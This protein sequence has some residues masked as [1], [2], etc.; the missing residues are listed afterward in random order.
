MAAKRGKLVQVGTYLSP[1]MAV[2]LKRLSGLTRVSQ[3]AYF[4]E[5]IEDLLR[6]YKGSVRKKRAKIGQLG[7]FNEK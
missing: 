4:R 2:R 5:A 3:A 6:K 7:D 1:E